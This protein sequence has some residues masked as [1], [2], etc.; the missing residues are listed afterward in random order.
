PTR[1]HSLLALTGSEQLKTKHMNNL[2]LVNDSTLLS[3]SKV[4]QIDRTLYR[5]IT[6]TVDVRA[7][8]YIFSPL[9]NQRKKAR[10]QLNQA[11]VKRRV[12]AVQGMNTNASVVSTQYVQLALPL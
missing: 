8:Q 7:P 4:Y 9:P 6:S 3:R 2:T 5:F 10:L 11:N 12:Y 1:K